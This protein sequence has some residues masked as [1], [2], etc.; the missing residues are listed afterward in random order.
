LLR[1][2]NNSR[3]APIQQAQQEAQQELLLPLLLLPVHREV[4]VQVKA[5]EE[6]VREMVRD[7]GVVRDEGKAVAVVAEEQEVAKDGG[8][9]SEK[10]SS[11]NY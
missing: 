10:T 3:Q 9:A 7:E 6:M 1:L 4:T 2:C 11:G 5:V 8:E